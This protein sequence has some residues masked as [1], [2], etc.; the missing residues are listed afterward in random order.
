MARKE[1]VRKRIGQL[2]N[3]ASTHWESDFE[4]KVEPLVGIERQGPDVQRDTSSN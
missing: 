1:P 3:R 4:E 2:P